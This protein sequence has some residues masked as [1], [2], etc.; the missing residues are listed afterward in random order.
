MSIDKAKTIA[1]FER[2]SG[3]G[4]DGFIRDADEVFVEGAAF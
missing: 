4:I 1:F 2:N 3:F